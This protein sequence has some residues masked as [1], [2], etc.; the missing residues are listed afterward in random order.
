MASRAPIALDPG[1]G[2]CSI[3][4]SAL[5]DADII[6]STTRART[7]LAIRVGTASV[8]SHAALYCGSGSI[9]EAIGQGVVSRSIDD[10]LADDALAVTYRSPDMKPGISS[11]IIKF[12][13]AQIGKSYDLRGALSADSLILCLVSG[14]RPSAFFCSELVVEAYKRGGLPLTTLPSQCY[15]PDDLAQIAI[16]RLVYVGHLK[17][18]T[19][20]FPVISP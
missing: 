8:V 16:Q 4:Y 12:A 2:G 14:P 6:V 18:N 9:I 19:S 15:T 17:G 5:Q 7:S 1:I 10:A 20:W 3:G 13:S 11:A